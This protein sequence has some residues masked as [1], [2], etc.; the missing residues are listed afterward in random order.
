MPTGTKR[1]RIDSRVIYGQRGIGTR[2]RTQPATGVGKM[3]R[4]AYCH[5]SVS[6]ASGR[7]LISAPTQCESGAP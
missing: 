3:G 1:K 5:I 7:R 4:D 2:M 6:D